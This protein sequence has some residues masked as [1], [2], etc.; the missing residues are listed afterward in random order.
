MYLIYLLLLFFGGGWGVGGGGGWGGGGF[1]TYYCGNYGQNLRIW[2]LNIAIVDHRHRN[3]Q[4]KISTV[5]LFKSGIRQ[6]EKYVC[7]IN[8]IC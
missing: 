1:T 2:K 5:S 6:K 3:M 7:K 8:G 4:L